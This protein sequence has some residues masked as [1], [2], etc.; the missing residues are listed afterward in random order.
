MTDPRVDRLERDVDNVQTQI[1][2]LHSGSMQLVT[3]AFT[4]MERRLTEKLDRQTKDLK[5]EIT[6]LRAV[7]VPMNEHKILM[8]RVD[9]L[10]RQNQRGQGDWDRMVPQVATLWEERTQRSGASA[11]WRVVVAVG[12]FIVIILTAA[13]LAHSLGLYH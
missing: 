11:V 6:E 4:E 10:Y 3:T 5:G 1:N 2:N 7:M 9:E 8:E 13:N 12:G